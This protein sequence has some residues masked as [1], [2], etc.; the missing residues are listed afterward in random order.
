[1]FK[2]QTLYSYTSLQ[3]QSLNLIKA[4]KYKTNPKQ[5]LEQC[6]HKKNLVDAKLK[7]QT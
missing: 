7:W 3:A 6:E 1:M 2:V 5:N 4:R